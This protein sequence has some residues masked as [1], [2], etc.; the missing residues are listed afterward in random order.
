MIQLGGA[1]SEVVATTADDT[2][3]STGEPCKKVSVTNAYVSS[4]N[5]LNDG[6]GFAVNSSITN[7][8][9]YYRLNF[10]YEVFCRRPPGAAA[11]VL[12][13][14]PRS[15]CP[16]STHSRLPRQTYPR[17]VDSDLDNY[18]K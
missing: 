7:R 4:V 6:K 16:P 8:T 10:T 3:V 5:A 12:L 15:H 13:I 9:H 17:S 11:A 18:H 14:T 1:Y 2:R